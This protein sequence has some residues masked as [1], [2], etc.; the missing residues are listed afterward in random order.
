MLGLGP[1]SLFFSCVVPL[2]SPSFSGFPTL[3]H[4][5]KGKWNLS[6]YYVLEPKACKSWLS[7]GVH[8]ARLPSGCLAADPSTPWVSLLHHS[9]SSHQHTLDH[10]AEKTK[11]SPGKQIHVSKAQQV[12]LPSAADRETQLESHWQR[13]MWCCGSITL[14]PQAMVPAHSSRWTP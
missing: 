9:S 8:F 3:C 13:H 4:M 6:D 5:L 11:A 1:C 7:F 14:G 12:C 10:E 2:F